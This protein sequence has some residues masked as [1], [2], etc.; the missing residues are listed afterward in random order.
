MPGTGQI[1]EK[2]SHY[3]HSSRYQAVYWDVD[4]CESECCFGITDSKLLSLS[5]FD[6]K[7]SS[8]HSDVLL[9]YSSASSLSS[10]SFNYNDNN[11][12]V[13]NQSCTQL[14]DRCLHRLL[15]IPVSE[16][17]M[18]LNDETTILTNTDNNNNNN[19]NNLSRN[20][21]INAS[22]STLHYSSSSNGGPRGGGVML[23]ID[24]ISFTVI[25]LISFT[26]YCF[27]WLQSIHNSLNNFTL[28]PV[29][30][31]L[32]RLGT[33]ISNTLT[34]TINTTNTTATAKMTIINTVT[35]RHVILMP[36]CII[37]NSPTQHPLSISTVLL[38]PH[39][40]R[41]DEEK[42]HSSLSQFNPVPNV[43][44]LKSDRTS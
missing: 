15:S 17:P 11:E 32:C 26:F 10:S 30:L 4:T 28:L 3:H 9:S 40:L 36:N 14:R 21:S 29:W 12:D 34:K 13:N 39:S 7:Q 43:I 31:N 41:E 6:S 8:L 22:L 38:T 35:N 19:D 24:N 27:I 1:Q 20:D 23:K 42:G 44:H 5:T 33:I 25:F 2:K 37:S 16:F 18:N